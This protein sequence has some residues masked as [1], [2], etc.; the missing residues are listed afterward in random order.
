MQFLHIFSS[1]FFLE[2]SC[3]V[4]TQQAAHYVKAPYV[5]LLLDQDSWEYLCA[6]QSRRYCQ[7]IISRNKTVFSF[8]RPD[9]SPQR[10]VSVGDWSGS[11]NA[12]GGKTFWFVCILF[13]LKGQHAATVPLQNTVG[14]VLSLKCLIPHKDNHTNSTVKSPNGRFLPTVYTWILTINTLNIF[15]SFIQ[16]LSMLPWMCACLCARVHR[17]R[18]VG[19]SVSG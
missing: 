18:D 9:L 6:A 15:S 5:A 3:C 7:V 1:T 17:G 14:G 12:T 13:K 11:T 10:S 16:A 8:A 19:D 2:T 4:K